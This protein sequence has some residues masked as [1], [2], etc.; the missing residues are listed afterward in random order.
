MILSNALVA[1][2]IFAGLMDV[3]MGQANGYLR[4][5]RNAIGERNVL[6]R[7]NATPTCLDPKSIATASADDGQQQGDAGIA[8]GQA[9][10]E[11]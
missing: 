1:L 7:A 4:N 10:S 2:A 8:V 5:R 3:T 6:E 11:T 9:K